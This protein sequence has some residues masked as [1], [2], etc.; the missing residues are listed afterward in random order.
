MFVDEEEH[1]RLWLIYHPAEFLY[2]HISRR[3]ARSQV[4]VSYLLIVV[5]LSLRQPR[6]VRDEEEH[7]DESTV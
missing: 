7:L 1:S 4:T 3:L 6:H 2:L 5:P